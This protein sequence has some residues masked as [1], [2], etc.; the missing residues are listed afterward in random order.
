MERGVTAQRACQIVGISSG[1]L[2]PEGSGQRSGSPGDAPVKLAVFRRYYNE[3][4]PY[5]SL[6]YCT[7]AEAMSLSSKDSS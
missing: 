6:G 3:Q 1:A 7:P 4:R 5:S 2:A